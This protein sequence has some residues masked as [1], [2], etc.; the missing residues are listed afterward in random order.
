MY[1]LGEPIH[2]FLED[3]FLEVKL[4]CIQF[5]FENE[6]ICQIVLKKV[7][8]ILPLKVYECA[9]FPTVLPE[10]DI[11][12]FLVFANLLGVTLY[13]RIVLCAFPPLFVR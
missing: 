1:L 7:E 9:Y 8:P 13:L 4:L 3:K 10:M 2:R 11:N 12:K 6:W 5:N